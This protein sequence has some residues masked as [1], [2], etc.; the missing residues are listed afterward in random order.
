M[1]RKQGTLGA[2]QEFQ[3]VVHTD[4]TTA[5]ESHEVR[6]RFQYPDGWV[7]VVFQYMVIQVF[8]VH[9]HGKVLILSKNKVFSKLETQNKS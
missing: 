4:S 5:V 1:H 3:E 2:I 7:Q 8:Y 9:W 6:T